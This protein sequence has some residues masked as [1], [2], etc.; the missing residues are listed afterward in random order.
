LLDS[1]YANCKRLWRGV[2]IADPQILN[3]GALNTDGTATAEVTLS[4]DTSDGI[5]TPVASVSAAQMD[6]YIDNPLL[7]AIPTELNGGTNTGLPS[8]YITNPLMN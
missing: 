3:D 4:T 2:S 5:A 6:A 1:I 7:T 8:S